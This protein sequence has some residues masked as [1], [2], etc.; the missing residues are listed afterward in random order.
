MQVKVE[1]AAGQSEYKGEI[2]YFCCNACKQKFDQMPM[3]YTSGT[4]AG[5][6]RG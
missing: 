1:S 4:E 5:A 3:A 6:P 2:Y